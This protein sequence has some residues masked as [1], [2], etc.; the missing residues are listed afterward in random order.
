[1]QTANEAVPGRVPPLLVS[2]LKCH[3]AVGDCDPDWLGDPSPPSGLRAAQGG[4]SLLGPPLPSL[5]LL[6]SV[7]KACFLGGAQLFRAQL[8]H[9]NHAGPR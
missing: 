5:Q 2:A 4:S 6:A 7:G 3:P 1:M 8:H 9:G